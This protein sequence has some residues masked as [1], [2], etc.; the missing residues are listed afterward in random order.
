MSVYAFCS[1]GGSPGVTT[2][3]L[4]MALTWPRPVL[5]AECDPAGGA[6]LA[7]LFAGHLPAPRGLLGAAFDAG[8]GPVTL[9]SGPGGQ[10]APLDGSGSRTFLA[11]LSD[12]RQA[13]GLAPAWPAIVRML[14]AQPADVLADCG[15]LDAAD[16]QPIAVLAEADLVLL[17][18]RPTLRQVAAARPRI[19]MLTQLRGGT[20]QIRLVLTGDQGHRPGEVGKTLGAPVLAVL[21]SDPRTAAVLADGTGRRGSLTDRPL[22]RA[23]RTAAKALSTAVPA[24]LRAATPHDSLPHDSPLVGSSGSNGSGANGYG[25]AKGHRR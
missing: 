23:A 19:E 20:E 11:G 21:P 7:G 10:L 9:S 1:P 8:V 3:A 22:M 18:L 25:G 17:V 14:A 16:V 5:L 6:I 2:A 13:P 4:A 24:P 15:R 12:P